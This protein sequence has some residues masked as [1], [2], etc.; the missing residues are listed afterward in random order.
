MAERLDLRVKDLI[1]DACRLMKEHHI[2]I[3]L[4]AMHVYA[5]A[6]PF[7]PCQTQF[8]RLFSNIDS[9][10]FPSVKGNVVSNWDACLQ[11]IDVGNVI[12]AMEYSSDGQSIAVGIIG[13]NGFNVQLLDAFTGNLLLNLPVGSRSG[14]LAL[15]P[16][17]DRVVCSSGSTIKVYNCRSGK[18][19]LEETVTGNGSEIIAA[20]FSASGESIVVCSHDNTLRSWDI[21]TGRELST[22]RLARREGYE[23]AKISHDGT[24]IIAWGSRGLVML[25]CRTGKKIRKYDTSEVT[26]AIFSPDDT[27]I[28]VASSDTFVRIWSSLNGKRLLKLKGH[29]STVNSLAFSPNNRF[30]VSRSRE[31]RLWDGE[32]GE[33]LQTLRIRGWTGVVVDISPD[34]RRVIAG[35]ETG[36]LQ[37]WDLTAK[38]SKSD[39]TVDEHF[40]GPV[41]RIEM[42]QD[43]AR[44][45]TGAIDSSV[46]KVWDMD[47]GLQLL[48]IPGLPRHPSSLNISQDGAIIVAWT[49]STGRVW[50]GRTGMERSQLDSRSPGREFDSSQ[51][52]PIMAEQDGAAILSDRPVFICLDRESRSVMLWDLATGISR[53]LKSE[54]RPSSVIAIATSQDGVYV[55]C[56]LKH[57]EIIE[58]VDIKSGEVIS[59]L[60]G[61]GSAAYHIAI[62]PD[63]E[64]VLACASGR[65]GRAWELKTGKAIE[66]LCNALRVVES[67]DMNVT[68]FFFLC[69]GSFIATQMI[70]RHH[71]KTL[72]DDLKIWDVYTGEEVVETKP[73]IPA[74]PPSLPETQAIRD[75]LVCPDRWIH[76]V[77]S[78]KRRYPVCYIPLSY[79]IIWSSRFRG[80]VGTVGFD[81]GRVLTFRMPVPRQGS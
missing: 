27:R 9:S 1:H 69:G 6:L 67:W 68:K 17:C 12:K 58:I 3:S 77:Y 45:V 7:I 49:D 23:S 47:T 15:S 33:M 65:P 73:R 5:S 16:D 78:D 29:I 66:P 42:S 61:L 8:S 57:E 70:H 50:D 72:R 20:S 60:R 56:G 81:N 22:T 53:S 31:V 39:T 44:S 38:Q 34:C 48:E 35:S 37:V 64:I 24:K 21:R 51:N 25:D 14:F 79:G 2:I 76:V 46:L 43:G 62:S 32:R 30:I 4:G 74:I 63:N 80:D 11:S 54:P 71:R 75:H 26:S 59:T 19:L 55:A 18:R 28:A 13:A 10:I 41:H 40:G 52:L 36:R